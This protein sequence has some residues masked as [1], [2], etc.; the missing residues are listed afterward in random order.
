MGC[1]DLKFQ[2]ESN[3][4]S[5]LCFALSADFS[6]FSVDL[7]FLK[8]ARDIVTLTKTFLIELQDVFIRMLKGRELCKI[9][10]L[11]G[12]EFQFQ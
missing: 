2:L 11:Q 12:I 1:P 8:E 7:G 5:R 10:L 3:A 4:R 9:E 6:C